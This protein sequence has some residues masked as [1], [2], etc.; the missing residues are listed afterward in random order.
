MMNYIITL[1]TEEKGVNFIY[2]AAAPTRQVSYQV[3]HRHTGK[4]PPRLPEMVRLDD[5]GSGAFC[6]LNSRKVMPEI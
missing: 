3:Q 2:T 6:Y 1:K 5:A 4:Q